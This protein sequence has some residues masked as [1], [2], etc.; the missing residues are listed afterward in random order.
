M[1]RTIL[2]LSAA[3]LTLGLETHAQQQQPGHEQAIAAIRKLGG[4]VTFDATK[5]DGPVSVV[6]T[7]SKSPTECLPYLQRVNNLHTC[8]L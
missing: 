5:S 4:E 6:L 3:A 1:R 2:L 7:G 8:D